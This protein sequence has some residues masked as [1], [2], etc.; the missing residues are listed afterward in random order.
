MLAVARRVSRPSVHGF[1]WNDEYQRAGVG[2]SGR[3]P[4]DR[5]LWNR[6][7]RRRF[8][9]RSGDFPRFCGL[10]AHHSN[11]DR[12][13]HAVIGRRFG[14][15]HPH[16]THFDGV[17]APPGSAAGCAGGR[18]AAHSVRGVIFAC[19]RHSGHHH[20]GR[21]CGF[22][23]VGDQS[24]VH[25]RRRSLHQRIQPGDPALPRNP[26]PRSLARRRTDRR[27]YWPQRLAAPIG[28]HSVQRILR[29]PL[30]NLGL[31]RRC[32]HEERR[33]SDRRRARLGR[34]ADRQTRAV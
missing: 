23:R 27:G 16:H 33:N 24:P 14:R 11:G 26:V 4:A 6:R 20:R 8:C 7:R 3:Q 13:P 2:A 15:P 32:A 19:R 22:G 34:Q 9:P 31:Q 21:R 17:G 25:E 10:H 29:L 12:R 30:Q 18:P 1:D 5:P 28:S